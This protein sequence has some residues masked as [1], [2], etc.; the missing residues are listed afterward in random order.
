MAVSNMENLCA[1]ALDGLSQE[2][3]GGGYGA[4]TDSTV[5]QTPSSGATGTQE[6]QGATPISFEGDGGENMRDVAT[7]QGNSGD[8]GGLR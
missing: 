8:R 4:L 7:R 3:V 6:P 2:L 1:S 5:S